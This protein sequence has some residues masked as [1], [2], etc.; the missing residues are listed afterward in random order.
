MPRRLKTFTCSSENC[1]NTFQGKRRKDLCEK[2]YNTQYRKVCTVCGDS[3]HLDQYKQG[4][5]NELKIGR[6][7]SLLDIPSFNTFKSSPIKYTPVQP[8]RTIGP[9]GTTM[10]TVRR[11]RKMRLIR[12]VR[13]CVMKEKSVSLGEKT[14]KCY[15][16]AKYG[17]HKG[18]CDIC[19]KSI[20]R[21]TGCAKISHCDKCDLYYTRADHLIDYRKF[22]V[23]DSRV[24]KKTIFKIDYE[25]RFNG[26]NG[27]GKKIATIYLPIPKIKYPKVKVGQ[28]Y[29]LGQDYILN[30]PDR[31]YSL[32]DLEYITATVIARPKK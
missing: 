24:H 6:V 20:I 19:K 16:C 10:P 18:K 31:S 9:I 13:R 26:D 2:C 29:E 22:V 7:N 1:N 4:M 28:T 17:G 30:F 27:N 23:N 15:G 14:I 11:S 32:D 21:Y 25:T 5:R 8:I 3:Y 12:P